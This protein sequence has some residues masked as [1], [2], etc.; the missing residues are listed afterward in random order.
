MTEPFDPQTAKGLTVDLYY[1]SYESTSCVWNRP[2]ARPTSVTIVAIRDETTSRSQAA[3]QPLPEDLRAPFT[4]TPERPAAVLVKRRVGRTI[5][6]IEP[7]TP[8]EAGRTS[9]MAGGCYAGT[10]DS[11]FSE[12]TGFYGAVSVHDYSETWAAYRAM[13]VD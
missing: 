3:L 12:I 4:A 13:S 9:F 8:P 11:R 5:W 7:L 1:G 6:H 10:S 2:G